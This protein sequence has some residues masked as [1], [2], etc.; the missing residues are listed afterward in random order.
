MNATINKLTA[1]ILAVQMLCTM[2]ACGG[3]SGDG[4]E[5]VYDPNVAVDVE[6][7]ITI[8]FWHTRGGDHATLL[9]EQIQRF[10]ETNGKGITVIGTY[11]GSYYDVLSKTKTAFK[12]DMAPVMVLIGAGGIEELAEN[13]ALADLS[14]YVERDNWDLNNIPESLH[15]YMEHYDDQI[16]HFPYLVSSAVLYYNK[17]MLTKEPESLEELAAMAKTIKDTTGVTGM[18]IALDCGFVQRP[19]LKSLGAPGLTQVGGKAPAL[20]DDGSL[21]RMLSDWTAWIADGRCAKLNVTDSTT[22][23]K[24][25]LINGKLA[26]YM[27][28]SAGM[29]EMVADCQKAGVNLG[30]AKFVGYGGYCASIGGG[31]LSVLSNAT[32]Q[33]VAA[34]WEFIKFMYEDRQVVEN[35]T[36]TGYLPYTVSAGTNADMLAYWEANPQ[37]KVGYDQLT[38][39]TYNDWSIYLETWRDQVSA[40]I[41]YVIV[42]GTMT[43]EEAVD[44]LRRHAK[45]IFPAS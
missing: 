21:T 1:A 41:S 30:V 12:S 24:N 16:I 19:I 43:P 22:K 37:A 15:Y 9:D 34:A 38:Y 32:S 8:E 26:S 4:G 39:A 23:M 36:R 25:D 7:P 14:A 5:D 10:N 44:Y 20:L 27:A 18:G 6:G 40:A 42:D 33:E 3:G 17:D 13:G 35:A 29:N 28:S 11:Q 2:A 31:G 45:V